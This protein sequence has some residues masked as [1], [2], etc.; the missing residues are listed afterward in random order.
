MKA[1]ELA[2]KL[3]EHPEFEVMISIFENDGSAYGLGLR[4]FSITGIGDTGHSMK[5]IKLDIDEK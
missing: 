2:E 3:L 4:T 5:V 1:K